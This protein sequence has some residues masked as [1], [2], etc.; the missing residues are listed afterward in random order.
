MRPRGYD[1]QEGYSQGSHMEP[2]S[3]SWDGEK[4]ERSKDLG[5]KSH[6]S[7]HGPTWALILGEGT[8]S[9]SQP[10]SG[11]CALGQSQ[12]SLLFSPALPQY[13]R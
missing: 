6:W 12:L 9:R 13:L 7:Y 5:S 11:F 4:P 10:N 2:G 8:M 3:R 1:R